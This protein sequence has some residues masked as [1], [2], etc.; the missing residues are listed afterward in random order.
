M[1]DK[2]RKVLVEQLAEINA[3]YDNNDYLESNS[4][5]YCACINMI[6]SIG[7]S[8]NIEFTEEELSATI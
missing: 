6:I 3:S 5:V 7:R 8:F 2:L 1:I 4:D